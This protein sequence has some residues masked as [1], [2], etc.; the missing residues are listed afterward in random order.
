MTRIVWAR[1][2]DVNRPLDGH[3]ADAHPAGTRRRAPATPAT[4]PRPASTIQ[5]AGQHHD[6]IAHHEGQ[7]V[8]S[9]TGGRKHAQRHVTGIDALAVG[10]LADGVWQRPT[11]AWPNEH[12]HVQSFGHGLGAGRMIGID[13]GQ[14]DRPDRAVTVGG[15][16]DRP[17]QPRPGRVARVHQ[18]EPCPS[19]HEVRVDRLARDPAA[20]RH[21]DANHAIGDA[22]HEDLA[23]GPGRQS[24]AD[25]LERVGM[26]ELLEGR[27]RR[28][29]QVEPTFGHR[30]QGIGRAHPGLFDHLVAFERGHGP[31][32]QFGDEEPRIEAARQRRRRH[33]S[34]ERHQPVRPERE[35]ELGGERRE[36]DLARHER[37]PSRAEQP[38]RRWGR[39]GHEDTG[40]LER[41]TDRGDEGAQRRHRV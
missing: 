9:R 16:C 38:W 15:L 35:I 1:P 39:V 4:P 37:G 14:R 3:P 36:P 5:V 22:F 30:R 29:P 24:R 33:P 21:L 6:P 11:A 28:Q 31:N 18:H 2:G 34:G 13:V 20:G 32:G 40:L 10:E 23:E 25:R 12:R 26:L 8:R 27:A 7:V 19:T 17:V 41:L